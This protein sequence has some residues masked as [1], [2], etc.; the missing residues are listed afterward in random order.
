MITNYVGDPAICSCTRND[1]L[2]FWQFLLTRLLS[3]LPLLKEIGQ[4]LV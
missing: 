4:L 3:T 1:F 2:F